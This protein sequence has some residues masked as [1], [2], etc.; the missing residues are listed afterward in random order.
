MDR[1]T[2]TRTGQEQGQRDRNSDR[3][4]VT[5]GQEQRGRN[6]HI[7]TITGTEEQSLGQ[8]DRDKGTIERTGL[9][10]W[11]GTI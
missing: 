4:T 9:G 7:G 11:T 2:W 8:R 6:S 10:K 1:D 3:G 5:E